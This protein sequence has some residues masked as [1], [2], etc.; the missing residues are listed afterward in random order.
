[1]GRDIAADGADPAGPEV[2][3]TMA[4]SVDVEFAGTGKFGQGDSDPSRSQVRFRLC[5]SRG[6]DGSA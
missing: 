4:A 3:E 5:R 2:R 6:S 1:M